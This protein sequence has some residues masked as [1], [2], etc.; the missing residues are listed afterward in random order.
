M[1]A[2]KVSTAKKV[3]QGG[4]IR[5]EEE[6]SQKSSI[7]GERG[8][9]GGH[10]HS[11]ST[12]PTAMGDLVSSQP[13]ESAHIPNCIYDKSPKSQKER[14]ISDGITIY[15]ASENC[16]EMKNE[17]NDTPVAKMGEEAADI[18]TALHMKRDRLRR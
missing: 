2:D 9:R 11:R 12:T 5:E 3:D 7:I 13:I 17:A 18:G 4:R 10:R 14:R 6:I 1:G 16:E 8:D 15:G